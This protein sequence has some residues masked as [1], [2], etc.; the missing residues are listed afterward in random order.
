MAKSRS[1][2][3]APRVA[4]NK[5]VSIP[6]L[7]LCGAHLLAKLAYKYISSDLLDKFTVHLWSE[8]LRDLPSR[9]LSFVAN[10]SSEIQSLVPNAF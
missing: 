5:T 4:L 9:W 3:N 8:D 10:R 1:Y 2:F 7:E 6:R